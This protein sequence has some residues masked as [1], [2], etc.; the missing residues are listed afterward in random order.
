MESPE[1]GPGPLSGGQLV[2]RGVQVL[3]LGYG[4][5]GQGSRSSIWRTLV[6]RGVQVLYLGYG[7]I[8]Q[9]SRSSIWRT[10]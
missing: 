6:R 1:G 8:G 2:R 9:G 7:L 10:A 5:I 3:Y 4:L